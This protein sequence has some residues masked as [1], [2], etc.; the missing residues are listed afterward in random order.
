MSIETNP[1][2]LQEVAITSD[3]ESELAELPSKL[4]STYKRPADNDLSEPDLKR[5]RGSSAHKTWSYSRSTKLGEPEKDKHG[6]KLWYCSRCNHKGLS[7]TDRARRH[8][9]HRH[10]IRIVEDLGPIQQATK[11]TIRGLIA[12]QIG[13]QTGKDVEQERQLKA[14]IDQSAFE[15]ALVQFITRHNLSHRIVESPEL[16]VLLLSINYMAS[17]VLPASHS[18]LPK[19][20]QHTFTTHK[21]I[22][23]DQLHGSRSKI[24][25]STDMWSAPSHTGYQAIVAHFITADGSLSK[26]LLALKEH[27]GSH[28]GEA[29]AEV[30]LKALKDYE[31]EENRIGCFTLDN[32]SSN[33]TMMEALSS[34]LPSLNP[35]KQR[36]RC[37]GHVVNLA[38]QA[39]LFAKDSEALD[40]A[41]RQ[42]SQ[43]AKDE[44]QGLT[45]DTA[46]EWR[47]LGPLGRAHNT[48]IHIR[49]S[50]ER[51]QAF[52]KEAGRSIPRDNSTRW[53]SWYSLLHVL[54]EKK[55]HVNNY[56]DE[57]FDSL[58][59]DILSRD[60][61]LELQEYHDF[62][63]PFHEITQD[64]QFDKQT[65]DQ[66]LV[67]MDFLVTHLEAAKEHYQSNATV[68]SRVMT[69]WYKFDKYY[70]LTDDSPIYAAAV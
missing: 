47:K 21:R 16:R 25:L 23:K 35:V 63:K 41:V 30:V 59:N 56:Q 17:S 37:Q 24:H 55:V 34:R 45:A 11:Q 43:L 48:V 7:S 57:H 62:L 32:A 49:S 10:H 60:D 28:T 53:N 2:V 44:Q 38:A 69:C 66:V 33:D 20:L 51:Y 58:T 8:L 46:S 29:Q 27:K 61:W 39:F 54:L 64:G 68:L 52:K 6:H 12:R 40:E 15:E 31:I 9:H 42:L 26:A 3:D 22:V 18:S 14:A 67:S 4:S 1:L 19:L 65:I 5:A 13:L 36:L 50:N 70:G